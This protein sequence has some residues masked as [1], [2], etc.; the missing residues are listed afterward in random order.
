MKM[1]MKKLVSRSALVS[2]IKMFISL[3]SYLLVKLMT[4]AAGLL[5]F[6]G[7][8]LKIDLLAKLTIPLYGM[9]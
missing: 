7:K 3:I 9:V 2:L 5:K 8:I 1:E 6:L 4:L